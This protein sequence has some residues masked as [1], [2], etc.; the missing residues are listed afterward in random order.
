MERKKGRKA[1]KQRDKTKKINKRKK[2]EG[3]NIRDKLKE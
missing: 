1:V 3:K 2:K